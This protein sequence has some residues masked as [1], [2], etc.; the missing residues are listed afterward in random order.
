FLSPLVGM[1]M[2]QNVIDA[3]VEIDGEHEDVY[4]ENGEKLLAKLKEIDTIYTEKIADIP[5]ENRI[6][7][8]SER[9]YQYMAS[10]YGLKEGY[11]CAIDTEENGTPAQIKNLVE[12]IKENHVEA[13]FVETN[14]DKRP[15]ETVA[16]ETGVD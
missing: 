12:F 15:M 16:R 4:K 6:L 5:E 3:L 2:T 1:Q 8:T 7:V 10:D 14:V 13:L 9:A 11:I